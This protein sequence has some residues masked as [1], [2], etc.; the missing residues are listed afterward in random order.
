MIN[1]TI[2]S[3]AVISGAGQ[4]DQ[5]VVVVARNING[6]IQRY[7]EYFMPQELFGQL[8]NAFFVNC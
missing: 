8:S 4:E 7:V 3:V 2:E 6:M 1:G 5:L